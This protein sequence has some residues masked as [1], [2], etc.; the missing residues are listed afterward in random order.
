MAKIVEGE[1]RRRPG[2]WLLDYRDSTGARRLMTFRNKEDAEAALDELRRPLSVSADLD[3]SAVGP[4]LKTYFLLNPETRRL[5]IGRTQDIKA[6]VSALE[7]AGG[8]RLKLIGVIEGDHEQA[9]HHRFSADRMFGEWFNVSGRVLVAI[10][11]AFG[12]HTRAKA[13]PLD[14][15]LED[16]TKRHKTRVASLCSEF[17]TKT[18]KKTPSAAAVSDCLPERF[19]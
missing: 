16:E 12:V 2:R 9:W 6:R 3:V 8:T 19:N 1:N 15:A 14:L 10:N 17:A 11:E 7:T 18:N 4:G 5:K 13:S